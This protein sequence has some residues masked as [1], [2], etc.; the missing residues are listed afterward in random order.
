MRDEKLIGPDATDDEIV[1]AMHAF[2]RS[3]P[4]RL[5]TAS[6]YDAL[7]EPRQPNLPGTTDQYPNWR[8]PLPASLEEIR[9]DPRVR[10]IVAVLNTGRAVEEAQQRTGGGGTVR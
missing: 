1:V 2:L 5:V 7:D 9:T 10:R 8:I 6:L 3:T 4:C